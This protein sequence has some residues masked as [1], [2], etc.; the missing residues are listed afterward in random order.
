MG[1]SRKAKD[2]EGN[3]T[4]LISVPLVRTETFMSE[5]TPAFPG[6][7]PFPGPGGPAAWLSFHSWTKHKWHCGI[8]WS[9]G[10]YSETGVVLAV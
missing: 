6:T 7:F 9:S 8:A 5:A 4:K 2:A 10:K 1:G 3:T